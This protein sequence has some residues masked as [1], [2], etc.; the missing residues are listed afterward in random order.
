MNKKV[1]IILLGLVVVG[2]AAVFA[3]PTLKSKMQS[4]QIPQETPKVTFVDKVV[5]QGPIITDGNDLIVQIKYVG[6]LTDGK[7]F[8]E[9]FVREPYGGTF[10]AAP[11]ASGLKEGM[12]GMRVGGVRSITVPPELGFGKEGYGS[13][14]PNATLFYE[15]SLL[16][17]AETESGYVPEEYLLNPPM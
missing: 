14:P 10:E 13:V 7:V 4:S 16:Q 9:R 6:T 8:D 3:Y 5:G 1:I 15:V 11:F 17:I 12:V 2:A